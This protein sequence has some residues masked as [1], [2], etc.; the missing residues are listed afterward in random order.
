MTKTFILPPQLHLCSP[1]PLPFLPQRTYLKV[2]DSAFWFHPA[3]FTGQCWSD[4]VGC[5]GSA[6]WSLLFS[7]GGRELPAGETDLLSTHLMWDAVLASAPGSVHVHTRVCVCP[8]VHAPGSGMWHVD[9]W[10]FELVVTALFL[11]QWPQLPSC[12]RGAV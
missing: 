1:S 7:L 9:R 11:P 3:A 8:C 2:D 10:P 6:F 5:P 4:C 12:P